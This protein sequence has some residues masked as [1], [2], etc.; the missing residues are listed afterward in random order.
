MIRQAFGAFFLHL[1]SIDYQQLTEDNQKIFIY[2][3]YPI[4]YQM[5]FLF[6][7]VAYTPYPFLKKL[8]EKFYRNRGEGLN[9][10]RYSINKLFFI[11]Y[12][13][14]YPYPFLKSNR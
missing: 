3:P 10:I 7:I 13:P 12:L 6:Y 2:L 11:Y 5:N 4:C 8:N 14:I 1:N 9:F